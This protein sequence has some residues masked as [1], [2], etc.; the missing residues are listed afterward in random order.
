MTTGADG[1]NGGKG[2]I[3]AA[4]PF[5]GTATPIE[6][7]R[8]SLKRTSTIINTKGM[9]GTRSQRAERS[10]FGQSSVGGEVVIP[11]S[12]TSGVIVLPLILGAAASGTT[13]ALDD[14]LPQW[15]YQIDRVTKV[16]NYTDCM[17][18]KGIFKAQQGGFVELTLDLIGVDEVI[19]AA[20]GG[21]AWTQPTDPP[22]VFSDGSASVGGSSRQLFDMEI[23]VDNKVQARY[24]MSR[25][26]TRI[27]P[28]DDREVTVKFTCPFGSTEYDLYNA[29][30]AGIACSFTVTNGNYSTLFSMATVQ[31][32]AETPV[33]PGKGEIPL[34]MTG[35][36]RMTGSTR[37]LVVTHDSTG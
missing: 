9:S 34:T 19:V 6:I 2:N 15:Q 29:A 18:N 1:W 14:T 4:L 32:P 8:E 25:T 22:Y 17:V 7:I 28:A 20:G 11:F 24:G 31:F 26:P 5:A 30:L 33:I 23:T 12:P 27:A 35:V 37:E 16:M 13:F 36:A 3:Q 21:Q 10:R